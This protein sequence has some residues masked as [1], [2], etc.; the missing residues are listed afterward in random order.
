LQIIKSFLI[1]Q[2]L[3]LVDPPAFTV[4]SM[5]DFSKCLLITGRLSHFSYCLHETCILII[6]FLALFPNEF[7]LFQVSVTLINSMEFGINIA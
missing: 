1:A 7:L 2:G 5:W 3:L 6:H 4:P